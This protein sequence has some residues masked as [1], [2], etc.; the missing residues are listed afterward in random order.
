MVAIPIYGYTV[1]KSFF[2]ESNCKWPW[3]LVYSISGTLA[4]HDPGLIF[5]ILWQGHS[6]L[7]QDFYLISRF[8]RTYWSL[9]ESWYIY[10]SWLSKYMKIFQYQRSRLLHNVRPRSLRFT[11]TNIFFETAG[12]IGTQVSDHRLIGWLVYI[13]PS[14]SPRNG[15]IL[16]QIRHA[17]LTWLSYYL[18]VKANY[19]VWKSPFLEHVNMLK[20]IGDKK[21]VLKI[22]YASSCN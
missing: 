18:F 14:P 13:F 5:T 4:I 21:H 19:C 2:L 10:V 11:G 20:N 3:N 1:W 16:E 22:P 12:H 17:A 7:A 15:L 8:C 9:T 6:L